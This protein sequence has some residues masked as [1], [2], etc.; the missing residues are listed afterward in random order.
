MRADFICLVSVDDRYSFLNFLN[1]RV[2]KS[3]LHSF[4]PFIGRHS[5][6]ICQHF[7]RICLEVG[8]IGVVF[9]YQ[10]VHK[11]FGK[12]DIFFET[13]SELELL[14]FNI[15]LNDV[16]WFVGLAN[17]GH[18]GWSEVTFSSCHYNFYIIVFFIF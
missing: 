12:P 8:H 15:F 18:Q 1:Q 5:I 17:V 6:V 16:Y 14:I 10:F 9:F 2:L 13:V 3:A 7:S 11:L 4:D